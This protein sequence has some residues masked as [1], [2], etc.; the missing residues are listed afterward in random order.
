[1]S[2]YLGGINLTR[3]VAPKPMREWAARRLEL[4]KERNG[5]FT[6]PIAWTVSMTRLDEPFKTAAIIW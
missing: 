5:A 1:M 3:T 2:S 4:R 6:A